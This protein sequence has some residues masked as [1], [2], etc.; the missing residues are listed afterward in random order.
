[1]KFWEV[2]G[3]PLNPEDIVAV[4]NL[5]TGL[6]NVSYPAYFTGKFQLPEDKEPLDTFLD[7]SNWGKVIL[8]ILLWNNSLS[9][10]IYVTFS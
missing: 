8:S 3:Y 6:S 5:G 2:Q 1:M 10:L 7:M 9:Y 4:Q